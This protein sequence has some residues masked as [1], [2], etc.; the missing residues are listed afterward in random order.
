[1]SWTISWT[2]SAPRRPHGH[3]WPREGNVGRDRWFFRP[4]LGDIGG[5]MSCWLFG[6]KFPN[7]TIHVSIADLLTG[8][9]ERREPC[10]QSTWLAMPR[11]LLVRHE[12]NPRR[13]HR[14][15]G[16]ALRRGAWR[17]VVVLEE[18]ARKAGPIESGSHRVPMQGCP[19]IGPVQKIDGL[20]SELRL[21]NEVRPRA[22]WV[23][24]RKIPEGER[25]SHRRFSNQST[26]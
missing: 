23:G 22:R 9:L 21:V 19:G 7:G 26:T 14:G 12:R 5:V 10:K 15:E 24:Q 20:A 13:P 3:P 4:W 11:R 2:M 25:T 18:P 16:C 1:M 17:L 8:P 6:K